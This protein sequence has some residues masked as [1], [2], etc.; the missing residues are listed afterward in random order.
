[1]SDNGCCRLGSIYAARS[2]NHFV[3]LSIPAKRSDSGVGIHIWIDGGGVWTP[4]LAGLDAIDGPFAYMSALFA[5]I[6]SEK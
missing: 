4:C 1:M 3:C 5:Y 2:R 6:S